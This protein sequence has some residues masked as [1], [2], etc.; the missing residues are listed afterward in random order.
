MTNAVKED[1]EIT[2]RGRRRKGSIVGSA[3]GGRGDRPKLD[4]EI[5]CLEFIFFLLPILYYLFFN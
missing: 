4:T 2:S 5:A 1:D 3:A